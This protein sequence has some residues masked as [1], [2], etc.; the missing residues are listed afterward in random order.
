MMGIGL[1][2]IAGSATV[3]FLQLPDARVDAAAASID[4]RFQ[5]D[6]APGGEHDA[7]T[8]V[9]ND[10]PTAPFNAE[11]SIEELRPEALA[12]VRDDTLWIRNDEIDIWITLWMRIFAHG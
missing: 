9:K 5:P 2:V 4:T 3:R 8:V 11:Q 7:V 6:I 10:K 12:A 1:L